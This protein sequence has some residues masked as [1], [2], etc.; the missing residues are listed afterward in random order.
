MVLPKKSLKEQIEELRDLIRYHERKYYVD[1]DP[2]I[3][4]GE[5]DELMQRLRELE[6]AHPELITPDSPTQR[7]FDGTLE[8]FVQVQHK[9]AMLSLDNAYDFDALSEFDERVRRSLGVSGD[10][11]YVTELKIDG[12]G[13]ALLYEDGALVRGATRGNGSV[14]DEITEN[15]RTIR[16]VP[17]RLCSDAP[18]VPRVLEVRGEVFLGRDEF[19]RINRQREAA[20]LP[21]FANPR[22]SAAGSLRLLDVRDVASRKLDT[23]IYTI[24]YLEGDGISTHWEALR[25]LRSWGFK[26]NPLAR[27]C[28]G[29]EQVKA[30]CR[31]WEE[32]RHS[33]GYDTDG[34]VVKV[35]RLDYQ[36]ALGQ[37][38]KNPRWA[39]AF[40][41]PAEQA[42][43]KLLA[44][45]VQVGRTGAVTPV[46]HLEPVRLSGT[47]VKRAT[48]HNEDEIRRKDI[49]IGDIVLLEKAGEIIPQVVKPITARRTG[50]EKVFHMPK[51][52]PVCGSKLV[53]PQGEAIRR[54]VNSA[55]P[56]QVK[57][58]IMH[59]ASR[60]GL[61][62]DGL[63]P[64][65]VDMLVDRGM[66]RSFADL[67]RLD[68]EQLARLPRMAEKSAS[69][70]VAAIEKSKKV[71]FDRF[72]YALGIRHV[73]AYVARVLAEN[74]GSIDELIS[75]KAEQLAAI[76]GIGEVVAKSI[77]EYFSVEENVT[78]VRELLAEGVQLQY[79]ARR[80]EAP[81]PIAGKRFVLTGT[82]SSMKREEAK[83]RIEALG[84]RV[85][86]SVTKQ[87]DYVVVGEQPGSKLAKAEKLGI[88]TLSES[89]FLE[90]LK[91]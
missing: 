51:N 38:T 32:R 44:I 36:R 8:G 16:S 29:I 6:A 84:G 14:G 77:E 56:A 23:F 82:L 73:G 34:V 33:L 49:R 37:T 80:P 87:T 12:V 40:K 43:T 21:I 91:S 61:E 53:R 89:E 11:E 58:R 60:A 86:S 55:C 71:P 35:N 70:L 1:N 26:V 13:V 67:F 2:E 54:C 5:F 81:S 52:C 90:L 66:V 69:N 45:E 57:E 28:S 46:A 24:S 74:F 30:Y 31:E 47:T 42:T 64:A 20:G 39:I 76:H 19:E 7:I 48:L 79:P 85:T 78:A 65:L 4:D 63:G 17:L 25:L 88:T 27:L 3:S 59:F 68:Q 15:I 83:K 75:A 72:I 50:E 9:V 18:F 22:N 41:F 10:I 62:I